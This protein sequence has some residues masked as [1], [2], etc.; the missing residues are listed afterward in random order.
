MGG[1][2]F[3]YF[4]GKQVCVQLCLS[5]KNV[6]FQTQYLSTVSYVNSIAK[7]KISESLVRVLFTFNV[8][9]TLMMFG[10]LIDLVQLN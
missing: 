4:E 1:R 7:N 9:V 5:E 10:A 3:S 6:L 8:I 2:I